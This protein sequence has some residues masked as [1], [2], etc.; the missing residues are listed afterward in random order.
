[1]NNYVWSEESRF[2][3]DTPLQVMF[4]QKF[5]FVLPVI[6]KIAQNLTDYNIIH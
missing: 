1:M 5:N 4:V 3:I 6:S 2:V